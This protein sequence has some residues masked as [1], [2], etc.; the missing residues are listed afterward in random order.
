MDTQAYLM[1]LNTECGD[2]VEAIVFYDCIPARP[3]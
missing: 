1:G 2:L 3:R